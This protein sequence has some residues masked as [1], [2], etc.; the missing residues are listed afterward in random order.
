MLDGPFSVIEMPPDDY[1]RFSS[2]F[3]DQYKTEY[4][5]SSDQVN[6][7]NLK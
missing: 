5:M 7:N 3:F 4:D 2:K 6:F 1:K